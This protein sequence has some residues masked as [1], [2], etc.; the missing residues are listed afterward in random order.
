MS[1][2]P[3]Q[4]IFDLPYRT[5]LGAEDFLLSECNAGAVAYIDRW[6]DWPTPAVLL[7]GEEATGKTHLAHVWCLQSGAATVEAG[8]VTQEQVKALGNVSALVV[9]NLDDPK[10]D[11]QALFHLLNMSRERKIS[12]LLTSRTQ[13]GAM[14]IALPDLRSRMRALPHITLS[15][16]DDP[17]LKAILIKL[18]EDRQILVDPALINYIAA[19]MDRSMA[20]VLNTVDALDRYGLEKGRR[21]TRSLAR[22]VIDGLAHRT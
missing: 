10:R 8:S 15:Q 13:P 1:A 11:D 14:E 5:A 3:R 16:P 18:F 12:L 22:D 20:R 21:V 17:L 9:E 4:L 7:T 6:P 2:E 19:R